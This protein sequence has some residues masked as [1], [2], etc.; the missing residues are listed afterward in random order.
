MFG[1][2]GVL[3]AEVDASKRDAATNR[4]P[5]TV[6]LLPLVSAL[7]LQAVDGTLLRRSRPSL[8]QG[9]GRRPASGDRWGPAVGSRRPAAAGL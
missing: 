6:R 1:D 5:V 3:I 4:A 8:F 2:A 9:L 7:T